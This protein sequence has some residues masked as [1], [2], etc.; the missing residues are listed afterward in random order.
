MVGLDVPVH[1]TTPVLRDVSTNR[2]GL[3]WGPLR[4]DR[5]TLVATEKPF[6][7]ET[8]FSNMMRPGFRANCGILEAL[9]W[10]HAGI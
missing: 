6:A 4:I 7:K 8:P 1:H 10:N 5:G 3:M 9:G 2:P